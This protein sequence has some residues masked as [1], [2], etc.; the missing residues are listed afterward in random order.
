MLPVHND[1]NVELLIRKCN[2]FGDPGANCMF[3]NHSWLF[4]Q[5]VDNSSFLCEIR[6]LLEHVLHGF[7]T[8]MELTGVTSTAQL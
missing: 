5:V 2:H 1:Q 7:G 3:T 6:L 4:G 8:H